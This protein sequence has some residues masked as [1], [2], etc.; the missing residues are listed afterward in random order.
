MTEEEFIDTTPPSPHAEPEPEDTSVEPQDGDTEPQ[1]QPKQD[2]KPEEDE[3]AKRLARL[4]HE[5]REAKRIARQLKAENDAL[6]GNRQEQPDAEL[7]RRIEERAAAK[8]I[9]KQFTELCNTVYDKGVKELGKSEMDDV[10]KGLSD[11]TGTVIPPVLIEAAADAGDAHRVLKYLYDNPD[12]YDELLNMPI[13]R[14]GTKVARI[15]AKLEAQT[16]QV[17]KAPP[18]IK[19]ISGTSKADKSYD[20]M[21]REEYVRVRDQ[22]ELKRRGRL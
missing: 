3:N 20:E 12:Q 4:A 21:S 15:A 18:P 13:H 11:H 16:R 9:E 7:E 10:V 6:R 17:S 1:E 5:A 22:E 2:E 14:M 8:A 19:P